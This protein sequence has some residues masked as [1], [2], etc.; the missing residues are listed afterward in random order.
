MTGGADG[1]DS[2]GPRTIDE[3]NGDDDGGEVHGCPIIDTDF[4]IERPA[5]W[6]FDRLNAVRELAPIVANTTP[7]D[8]WMVSR[9]DEVKEALQRSD[10]FTNRV[11]SAL[12]D[13]N[14]KVRLIPQ[15]LIGQEHV[16]YRHVL[17]PWFSPGAVQRIAPLA[18]ER[19]IAIIEELQPK[20]SCDLAN[21]FAMLFPTEIFLGILGLP[22]EDGATLMPIV[23]TMFRGFFGGDPAET[24]AAIATAKAYFQ[25]A[26]DDRLVNPRDASTDFITYLLQA[27]VDDHPLPHEDVLTLCYTIM[28]AGLDTTRSELGYIFQHLATHPDDRQLLVD[29]PD[30]IP[31]A[32]EEFCRLYALVM[33]DGR[34]VAEDIDF[35]GC[36]M[37]EGDLVWLGLASAN[38]DPRKFDNPDEFQLDRAFNKHLGFAAGAHRCLGAHLARSELI[39]ALQEWLR[40]I[41]YFR[42]ADD[43]LT[44]RGGQLMLLR[45]P[46][47]WNV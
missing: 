44:E 11:T 20:G 16:K 43:D 28:L 24:T 22:V 18:R 19:C 47:E 4:R 26:I 8:F 2:G 36:P 13:P 41:P 7:H 42:L 25:A 31:A 45:V 37:K 5:F 27:R 17:N 40:R 3:H 1:S 29:H 33:Q 38:R 14:N 21:E 15:N 46:L 34:Y 32:I 30:K 10:V 39:I 35:H 9:Y 23:E 12:G 6:H